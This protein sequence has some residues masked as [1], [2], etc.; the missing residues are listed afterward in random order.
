MFPIQNIFTN[1]NNT[2]RP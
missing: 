1:Q 2:R